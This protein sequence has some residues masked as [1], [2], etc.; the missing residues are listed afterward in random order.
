MDGFPRRKLPTPHY[1]KLKELLDNQKLPPSDVERVNLAV[2][3]YKAWIRAMEDLRSEGDERIR[4][5]V[6]RLNEYKR[7][8]EVDVIW[9]SDNDFLYRQRGQLKLDSSI[10]EEFLPW[11]VDPRIISS[12]EGKIYSV[13]P[14]K[15]FSAVYFSA[16]LAVPAR[17]AGLEV[18]TKDHDFTVGRSVYLQASFSKGFPPEDTVVRDVYLAFLAAECKT[19]LDKTMFQEAVATAHDLKVAI[20][21]ARYYLLCEWLDMS[22]I[23]TATTD[24]DEVI[25]LRGKRIPSTRRERHATSEGRKAD[26]DWYLDYLQQNPVRPERVV[27][28]VE[29]MR[30]MFDLVNPD[31]RDVLEKGYF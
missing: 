29:H 23:S 7:F 14:R 4:D 10:T 16:S 11:L 26:R 17:G 20:Q 3:R 13:G 8:V 2:E 18:R 28:F 21:G 1:D 27:R 22:P 6:A 5:L 24:I 15:T 30:T 12:L 19:N 25:I 31:E 9:D